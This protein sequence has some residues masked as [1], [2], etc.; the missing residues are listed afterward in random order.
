MAFG[1]ASRACI[2]RNI[3]LLEI[4]KVVPILVR[5]YN[6]EFII[7]EDGV[8]RETGTDLVGKCSLFEAG[9]ALWEGG[10]EGLLRASFLGGRGDV[11]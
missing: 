7:A 10:E 5:E 3:L 8:A 6:F 11:W 9:A 2:G 1:L 4:N